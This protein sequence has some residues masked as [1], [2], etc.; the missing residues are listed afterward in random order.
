MNE[1]TN[2]LTRGVE[3][4]YPTKEE[5]EKILRNGKKLKLYQGFDPS[6]P[7]LHLGNFAGVMKLRQFQKLGHE[8]IFLIGDFTAMIGDPDKLSV[9]KPLTREETRHNSENWK[10]QIKNI[11]DF[12]GPNPAKL[13]YNSEW[14][15]KVSFKDLIEIASKFTTQ[16]ML[17][18]DMFQK[19]INE[20]RPVYLH[21]LL[22]P[23]AQAYDCVFMDVDLEL[24]GK[25]QTFNALAG[26]TL[27]NALKGKDKFVM[28][29]KLL[30]DTKGDKVGKT[31]GN[32]LF[33]DLTPEKF[34]GGIMSFPDEVIAL[35]FELLTEVDLA[36]IEEKIKEKPM[37]E[38]KRLAFE[39][40][41]LLWGEKS[42]KKAQ[43]EF[44]NIYQKN[45]VP[46]LETKIIKNIKL[47]DVLVE[48]NLV[49]SKS[50]AKRV[51]EQGGVD[52]GE[53]NVVNHNF[54]VP[55]NKEVIIKI[56]KTRF[57]KIRV[58]QK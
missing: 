6:M 12:E 35:G 27:M 4:I 43:T 9:R 31:T 48:L 30:V 46:N 7:S 28:T 11:I 19:R 40:V 45:A 2:L 50:E 26:R 3:N 56:G 41:K 29:T 17:E 58:N 55:A 10:D 5:L 53:E 20:G 39:I 1:I 49:K 54:E 32:A 25:D 8:I 37:A 23:V 52:V 34:Y 33:L 24:A 21:E 47:E 13:L 38:K 15:D 14:L 51:I 16:Q 44:E 36:G 18:R 22:Y 57:V 42:A